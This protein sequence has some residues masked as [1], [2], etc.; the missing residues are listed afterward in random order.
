M[1][2]AMNLK[3]IAYWAAYAV[4]S[5]FGLLILLAILGSAAYQITRLF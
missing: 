2:D 5:A 3:Q 1:T 4:M